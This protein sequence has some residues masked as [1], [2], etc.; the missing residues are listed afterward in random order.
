MIVRYYNVVL[1]CLTCHHSSFVEEV[2]PSA[3]ADVC[4]ESFESELTNIRRSLGWVCN[5]CRDFKSH[6]CELVTER[7]RETY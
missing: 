1:E 5:C 3:F 2:E 7:T 6:T 4:I